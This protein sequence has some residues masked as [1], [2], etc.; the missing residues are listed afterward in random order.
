MSVTRD[1]KNVSEAKAKKS[2][3]PK[4]A[5]GAKSSKSASKAG[6]K[7]VMS[8]GGMSLG[9]VLLAGVIIGGFVSFLIYLSLEVEVDEPVG[10]SSSVISKEAVQPKKEEMTNAE[11]LEEKSRFEFYSILPER[12]IEVPV[13]DVDPV[14]TFTKPMTHP[15]TAQPK[16]V[17]TPSETA[18]KNSIIKS[19]P[20][21][22]RYILQA[23]SFTRFKDADKRKATLA[24]MGVAS[25]I[26]A[27]SK[28]SQ[29][30]Y[31]VQVGPYSEIKK[32]N[33]IAALLK[34]NRIPSLLMKVKG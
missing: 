24:F 2:A 22:R 13:E 10:K 34:K 32:V 16:M 25:K 7:P 1:Y 28:P 5:R 15:Q 8:A 26:H 30:M 19:P 6:A 3:K 4:S 14:P 27:I 17:T 18:G 31:R 12:K 23:G 29:T 11:P 9:F 21:I 33:E 20:V